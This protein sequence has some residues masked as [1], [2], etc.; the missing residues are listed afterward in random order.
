M[1]SDMP[2]GETE[3]TS[4]AEVGVLS[5][6]DNLES[7]KPT[8]VGQLSVVAEPPYHAASGKICR[9]V[10]LTSLTSPRRSRTRLACRHA[11][12]WAF[13]PNVFLAVPEP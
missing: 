12:E 7:A 2:G 6:L 13:V 1:A 5:R 9:R 3:A 11:T 10:T 4:A 8:R